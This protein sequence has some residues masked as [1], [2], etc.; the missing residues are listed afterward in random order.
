MAYIAP[1]THQLTQQKSHGSKPKTKKSIYSIFIL[2]PSGCPVWYHIYDG[3]NH[4]D[5]LILSGFFTA[6][7]TFARE[8]TGGG[9]KTLEA[10]NTR[11]TFRHLGRGL[12]VICSEKDLAP[13][14]TEQVA[15]RIAKLLM[16]EYA[17]TIVDNRPA[18]THIP[19]L[20]KRIERIVDEA[21]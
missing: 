6:M 17:S 18:L 7:N 20:E 5:P 13:T 14:V 15:S 21:T 8:M 11:F 16:A 9:I 4:A 12:L 10:G 2:R 19:N 3:E 1:P